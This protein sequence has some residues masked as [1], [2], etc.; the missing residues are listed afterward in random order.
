[1]ANV[2]ASD[3]VIIRDMLKER[4]NESINALASVLRPETFQTLK[5]AL[6][7]TWVPLD[8]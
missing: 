5:T 2:K 7:I 4:G 1:M 8:V 6:S 3:I